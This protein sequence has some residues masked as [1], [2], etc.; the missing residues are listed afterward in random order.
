MPVKINKSVFRVRPDDGLQERGL[1]MT[2]VL[3]VS[4]EGPRVPTG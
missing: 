3:E 4:S 2:R 1:A